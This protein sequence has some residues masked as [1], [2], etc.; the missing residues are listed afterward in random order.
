MCPCPTGWGFASD[1]TVAMGKLAV[2]TG[3]WYLAEYENG[4]VKMN[5]APKTLKPV[6]EYLKA[7]RRFR[8]LTE[9]NIGEIRE[10]RDREWEEIKQKWLS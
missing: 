9:E 10:N 4:K 5:Q 7:Q 3:L 6:E 2:E 1:L 8:H